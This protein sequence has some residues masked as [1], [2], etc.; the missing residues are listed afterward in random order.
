MGASRR[1]LDVPHA[2]H[3]D[4]VLL[5]EVILLVDVALKRGED[6]SFVKEVFAAIP[7]EVE[8]RI[9]RDASRVRCF[10]PILRRNREVFKLLAEDDDRLLGQERVLRR[11]GPEIGSG[12]ATL[13]ELLLRRKEARSIA[14]AVKLLA[15]MLKEREDEFKAVGVE[16]ITE[17]AG[18]HTGWDRDRAWS[19]TSTPY[20]SS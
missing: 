20:S 5:R 17:S 15:R 4:Q 19:R 8:Q 13:E 2:K 14:R 12:R 6:V 10:L 9:V 11:R 1:T 16:L 3:V 7:L 18:Q